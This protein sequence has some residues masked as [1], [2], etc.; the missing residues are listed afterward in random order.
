MAAGDDPGLGERQGKLRRASAASQRTALRDRGKRQQPRHFAPSQA[1][2][3]PISERAHPAQ[4]RAAERG[5]DHLL[6]GR[7]AAQRRDGER[8][9]LHLEVD[10]DG[11]A[12]EFRHQLF[13]RRRAPR[14][15]LLEGAFRDA[16]A[17]AEDASSIR[18]VGKHQHPVPG[19]VDV[20]LQRIR[21]QVEGAA[22][23]RKGILRELERSAAVGVYAHAKK[24]SPP[25]ASTGRSSYLSTFFS[26]RMTL[27]LASF[28][29]VSV[30]FLL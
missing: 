11:D 7:Q 25:G 1:G 3:A 19:D 22:E 2:R 27:P 20:G 18:I 28:S 29:F 4:R 24:R 30:V 10:V 23:G 16:A 6:F 12:G 15:H 13:E 14:A 21:A 9:G 26:S 17:N 8:G 5:E